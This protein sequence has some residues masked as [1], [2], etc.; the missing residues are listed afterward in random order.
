M[1]GLLDRTLVLMSPGK[2]P[3]EAFRSE[4]W[5]PK[6]ARQEGDG[7]KG[8]VPH[9][10]LRMPPTSGRSPD[11]GEL[12]AKSHPTDTARARSCSTTRANALVVEAAVALQ[13]FAHPAAF[14]L[15]HRLH[16]HPEALG[17]GRVA[18]GDFE[19]LVALAGERRQHALGRG[20]L[21]PCSGQ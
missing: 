3:S 18:V 7:K 14:R 10:P 21:P 5:W 6:W 15:V 11:R 16:A 17:P 1:R 9:M 19:D 4:G 12:S 8:A 2:G 20:V 13:S